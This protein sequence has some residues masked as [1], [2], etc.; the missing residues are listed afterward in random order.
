MMWYCLPIDVQTRDWFAGKIGE[1]TYYTAYLFS[2]RLQ[3]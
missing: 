1:I 2:D 3:K